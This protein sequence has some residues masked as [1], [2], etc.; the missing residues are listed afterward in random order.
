MSLTAA[1][2]DALVEMLSACLRVRAGEELFGEV[3]EDRARNIAAALDGDYVMH[4]RNDDSSPNPISNGLRCGVL[5]RKE[6]DRV[7]RLIG[8]IRHLEDRLAR[9][10]GAD[11]KRKNADDRVKSEISALRWAVAI[12]TGRDL[13]PADA[14]GGPERHFTC[15]CTSG[16]H[17]KLTGC[18]GS[19]ATV[20]GGLCAWCVSEC[21]AALA[22]GG[23]P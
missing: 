2:L 3:I 1:Q 18:S 11:S 12:I 19:G 10:I 17:G 20:A 5:T 8:R 13:A 14:D 15:R 4:P 16:K 7:E 22:A 9:R 6:R 21:P 23:T